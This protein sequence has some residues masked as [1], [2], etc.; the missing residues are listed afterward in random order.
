MLYNMNLK[1]RQ[2]CIMLC[3]AAHGKSFERKKDLLAHL[4]QLA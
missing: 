4:S 1:M 2:F 3:K